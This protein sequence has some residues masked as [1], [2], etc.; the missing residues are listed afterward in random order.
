MTAMGNFSNMLISSNALNIIIG[1]I[2]KIT[3]E[4]IIM[5]LFTLL[6]VIFRHATIMDPNSYM[7]I[8][9]P[10]MEEGKQFWRNGKTL[11]N[12]AMACFGEFLFYLST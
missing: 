7:S 12:R 3:N 5:F 6:A 8:I 11:E 2:N 1:L 9:Q 4:N 10:M